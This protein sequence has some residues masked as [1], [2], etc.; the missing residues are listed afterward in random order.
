METIKKYRPLFQSKKVLKS[1]QLEQLTD[2]T[3]SLP[4]CFY[5]KFSNGIMSGFEI[6]VEK[7]NIIVSPGVFR[8]NHEMFVIDQDILIAYQAN[9]T[10]M[11][12]KLCFVGTK[13]TGEEEENEFYI[14][15]DELPSTKSDI[16][17]CRFRLQKGAKLRTKYDD[18]DDMSTEFDTVNLI[19]SPW[20]NQGCATLNPAILKR[21][22]KEMMGLQNNK[23]IDV[24][25]CMQIL[26]SSFAMPMEGI[27]SYFCFRDDMEMENLTNI[28]AYKKLRAIIGIEKDKERP[29]EKKPFPRRKIIID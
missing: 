22:A 3:F 17:L 10:L 26:C 7:D 14:T 20:S 24:Q 15:L 2:Q 28:Q 13:S 5:Y 6:A 8:Y 11:Y 21:F 9:D 19:H 12:L 18:F 29:T 27:L 25:F 16:E 4:N 1:T 23:S